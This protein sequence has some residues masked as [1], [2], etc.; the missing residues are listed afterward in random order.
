MTQKQEK[1]FAVQVDVELTEQF[2]VEAESEERAE[3]IAE[4]FVSS[5]IDGG[6]IPASAFDILVQAKVVTDENSK[7]DEDTRFELWYGSEGVAVTEYDESNPDNPAVVEEWWWTWD[8]V[9]SKL[10]GGNLHSPEIHV[11]GAP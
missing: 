7:P 8:E 10:L 5:D 1:L 11:E 3:E 4:Y 6:D 2:D 9:F